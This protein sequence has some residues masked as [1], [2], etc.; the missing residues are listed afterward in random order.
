MVEP[1]L[2][3]QFPRSTRKHL[4]PAQH[5]CA[6]LPRPQ[7]STRQTVRHRREI[8]TLPIARIHDAQNTTIG[9]VVDTEEAF[10]VR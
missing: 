1:I 2:Q 6:R 7:P 8:R 5:Y 3:D 10:A 4:I 9:G